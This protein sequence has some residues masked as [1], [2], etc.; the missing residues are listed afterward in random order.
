MLR[1][2]DVTTVVDI[3]ARDSG[4]TN[5]LQRCVTVGLISKMQAVIQGLRDGT[6]PLAEDART[7]A[8]AQ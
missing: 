8:I 4:T 5:Y 3:V 1:N 2:T 7:F 6:H